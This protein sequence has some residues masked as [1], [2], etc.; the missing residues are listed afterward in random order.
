[1]AAVV[2][3]YVMSCQRLQRA[4]PSATATS[5]TTGSAGS[6]SPTVR[7]A[8]T[9]SWTYCRAFSLGSHSKVVSFQINWSTG[10]S[11]TSNEKYVAT[12]IQ[13]S[14]LD[15]VPPSFLVGGGASTTVY[16]SPYEMFH[17]TEPLEISLR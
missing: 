15:F 16:P 5:S 13:K 11:N 12:E 7:E 10:H 3:I 14:I 17:T 4:S 1:M 8:C 9:T 6:H 2:L